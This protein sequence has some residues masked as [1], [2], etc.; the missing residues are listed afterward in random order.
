MALPGFQ[1]LSSS[2]VDSVR[3]VQAQLDKYELFI[4]H[5]TSIVY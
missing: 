3:L 1:R 2:E 5:I 4:D